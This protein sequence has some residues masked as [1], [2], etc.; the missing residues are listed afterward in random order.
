MVLNFT[1]CSP[2]AQTTHVLAPSMASASVP[3]TND[4]GNIT[5]GNANHCGCCQ[6]LT[7]KG[8]K[9]FSQCSNPECRRFMCMVCRY[10]PL[11]QPLLCSCCAPD[12]HK[13]QVNAK[14]GYTP[15][16]WTKRGWVDTRA[17]V[18]VY[19]WVPRVFTE[20]TPG[21]THHQ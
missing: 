11:F 6:S 17:P 1:S 3:F 20:F 2:F 7:D 9:R 16:E 21:R 18:S 5:L 12:Q 19:T 13:W 4:N 8:E 10:K 15:T 14:L